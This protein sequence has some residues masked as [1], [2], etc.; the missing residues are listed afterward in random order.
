MSGR[1]ARGIGLAVFLAG[2]SA[3]SVPGQADWTLFGA[4]ETEDARL[5]AFVKWTGV[6][7]RAARETG[8]TAPARCLA[9]MRACPGG[10]SWSDLIAEL[11]GRPLRDQLEAVN[12]FMNHS[13][14]I[15]DPDNWGVPD[16]WATPTEF[17]AKDGD[18]EDYAIS[19]YLALKRLGLPT[20]AM[21]II[22]LQDTNLGIAHAVLGV[23]DGQTI[24]ILDNQIAQVVAHDKVH[25]YRPIY[26]INEHAWWRHSGWQQAL[27]GA[28]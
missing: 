4:S 11:R 16:Y 2:L 21:R 15:L 24:W 3:L 12:R 28:Y 25:H 22:V 23:D 13:P 6:L 7:D 1:G 18:C 5:T 14:Y 26:S 8:P 10:A 19:K 20:E 27:R 17:F 9:P